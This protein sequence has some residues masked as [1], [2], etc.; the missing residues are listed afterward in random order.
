MELLGPNRALRQLRCS[1]YSKSGGRA[2]PCRGAG[3]AGYARRKLSRMSRRA[4]FIAAS[5]YPHQPPENAL[6]HGGKRGSNPL[7]DTA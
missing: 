1:R 7:G 4:I 6:F 5:Q 2:R 3:K